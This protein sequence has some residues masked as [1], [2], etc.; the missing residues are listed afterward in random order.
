M[1]AD[2]LVVTTLVVASLGSLAPSA[3]NA[4]D[5][6]SPCASLKRIVAAAPG[7]FAALTPDDGKGVAQPY[8]D[9]AQCSAARG[10]YQCA[11]TPH[12]DSASTADALEAVA[13]DIASCL[14]EATHDQNSP[15]RQHFYL[16]VPGKRT[17][18]TLTPAGSGKLRLSVSGK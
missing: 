9:D 5:A 1:K 13:A 15:A 4:D 2:M 11:W 6:P 14:P 8:G 3:A 7:G 12:R 18:I 10:S 17:E 16:G